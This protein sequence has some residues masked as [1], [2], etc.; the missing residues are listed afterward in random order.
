MNL[1]IKFLIAALLTINHG[2]VSLSSTEQ[3]PIVQLYNLDDLLT[4]IKDFPSEQLGLAQKSAE[5]LPQQDTRI[6]LTDHSSMSILAKYGYFE[7]SLKLAQEIQTNPNSRITTIRTRLL[8]A[9]LPTALH[10]EIATAL[11]EIRSQLNRQINLKITHVET[12]ATAWNTWAQTST[13]KWNQ[14]HAVLDQPEIEQFLQL[15]QPTALRR[16]EITSFNGQIAS[17][18]FIRQVAGMTLQPEE[19]GIVTSH[20]TVYTTGTTAEVQPTLSADN[21]QIVLNYHFATAKLG[22]IVVEEITT[23]TLG[24]NLKQN[25]RLPIENIT[26][27]HQITTGRTTLSH[28]QALLVHHATKMADGVPQVEAWIINWERVQ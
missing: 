12:T 28:K 22:D 21:R 24:L 25:T 11:Q 10:T 14:Q 1:P 4:P 18:N 3:A 9:Q 23:D 15:A 2:A 6:E 27:D 16:P 26:I 17:A 13:A 7:L 20:P 19:N 8:F 5:S